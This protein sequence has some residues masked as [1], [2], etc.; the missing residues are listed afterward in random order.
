MRIVSH[1]VVV[2]ARLEIWQDYQTMKMWLEVPISSVAGVLDQVRS[3]ALTFAREIEEQ[4]P[5]AGETKG[6]QATSAPPVP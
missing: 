6:G 3:R 2:Y 5:A 1:C 4:N